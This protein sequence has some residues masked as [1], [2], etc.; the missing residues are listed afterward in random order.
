MVGRKTMDI[1]LY[2]AQF[3]DIWTGM[4]LASG[5]AILNHGRRLSVLCW[6]LYVIICIGSSDSSYDMLTYR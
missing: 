3:Y 5:A 4:T 6:S 2:T 1:A